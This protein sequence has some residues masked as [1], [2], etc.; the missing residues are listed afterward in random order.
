MRISSEPNLDS[1]KQKQ[2][3]TRLL[4]MHGSKAAQYVGISSHLL[5]K[6]TGTIFVISGSAAQNVGGVKH[7]IG[8]NLKFNK[9]NEEVRFF[10]IKKFIIIIFK[11]FFFIIN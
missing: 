9:R 10:F 1:I 8:L 3:E 2:I 11:H 7:N 5:S 4:Y 6:I